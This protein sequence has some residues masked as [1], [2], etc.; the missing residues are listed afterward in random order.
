MVYTPA[1]HMC[2]AECLIQFGKQSLLELQIEL[3]CKTFIVLSIFVVL[4]MLIAMIVKLTTTYNVEDL[5]SR[6]LKLKIP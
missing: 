4:A 6:L 2:C 5:Y 1:L 3:S